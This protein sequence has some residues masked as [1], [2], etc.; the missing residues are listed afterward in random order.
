MEINFFFICLIK[1]GL[2]IYK[3]E[4]KIILTTTTTKT[5]N[6]FYQ[7]KILNFEKTH[8]HTHKY[9]SFEICPQVALVKSGKIN[10]V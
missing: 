6:I 2:T 7:I 4:N 10:F 1:K 9:H 5:I 8:K 3:S